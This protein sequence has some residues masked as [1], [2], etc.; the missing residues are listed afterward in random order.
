MVGKTFGKIILYLSEASMPMK[1][2]FAKPRPLSKKHSNLS[3]LHL[4]S[5]G[6][7]PSISQHGSRNV[8]QNPSQNP[9][10]NPSRNGSRNTSPNH[11]PNTLSYVSPTRTPSFGAL[12][13]LFS[14][15]KLSK[16]ETDPTV[17][18][19]AN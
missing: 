19:G 18:S 8:S 15:K 1:I 12:S 14:F 5:F 16:N 2:T 4:S 3:D 10:R 9:S 6:S 11:S 13:N 7:P 17:V